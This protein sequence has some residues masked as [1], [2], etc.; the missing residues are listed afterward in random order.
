ML[1]L[2]HDTI[3]KARVDETTFQL[4]SEANGKRKKYKVEG[5]QDS[6]I[7]IRES[8]EGHLSE[9]YYLV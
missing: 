9:L 5:I 6:A 3:K 8:V 2:E 7:Y 4:K 1:L